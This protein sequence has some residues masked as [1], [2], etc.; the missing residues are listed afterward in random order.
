M[1]KR[2]NLLLV[3]ITGAAF[4]A[5]LGML[6][7]PHSGRVTRRIVSRKGEHLAD[8]VVESIKEPIEHLSDLITEKFEILKSD[9]RSKFS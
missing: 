7:A 4:G 2:G 8:D 3:L 5:A 9:L 6:F 1:N